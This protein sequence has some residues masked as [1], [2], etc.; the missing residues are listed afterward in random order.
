MHSLRSD[1][2]RFASLT[3]SRSNSQ[4]HVSASRQGSAPLH[5][6]RPA[7]ASSPLSPWFPLSCSFGFEFFF[8]PLPG[9]L[10][11]SA[12]LERHSPPL[13]PPP[14]DRRPAALWLLQRLSG[15]CQQRR[16]EADLLPRP[17]FI[18]S[19]RTHALTPPASLSLS[20]LVCLRVCLED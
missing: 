12:G 20:E 19:P 15:F 16:G 6:L 5:I 2:S 10:S 9:F 11:R 4:V 14:T 18:S 7:I 8:S 13:S 3:A 1:S 17:T